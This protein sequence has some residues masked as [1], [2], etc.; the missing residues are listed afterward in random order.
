M[1]IQEAFDI[2]DDIAVGLASGVYRRL[3]GVVRYAIGENK[4]QI[5]KHLDPISIPKNQ[6]ASL[7]VAQKALNVAK[8]NKK[9]L[10]GAGVVVG[11]AAIGGGVYYGVSSYRRKKCQ[12]AF[13]R[14]IEA[15]RMGELTFEIIDNLEVALSGVKTIKMKPEE[16]LLLVGHIRDYTIKLAEN[17]NSK[18]EIKET[19][20]PIIDFMEYLKIQKN[21]LKDA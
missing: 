11:A 8:N 17:N 16:L 10:I 4:G 18:I 7:S 14:Y 21:I 3:G 1:V 9:L 2:P 5:V 12:D 20:A 13:K 6:D 19:E 15:I